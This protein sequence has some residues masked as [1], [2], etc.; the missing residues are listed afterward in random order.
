MP[1]HCE[2]MFTFIIKKVLR[3]RLRMIARIS[4]DE[5]VL[6]LC[7]TTA[8]VAMHDSYLKLK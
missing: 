5:G 8:E 2:Q 4:M 6:S 7:F 3:L 1:S